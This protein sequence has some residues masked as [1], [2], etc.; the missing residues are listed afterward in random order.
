VGHITFVHGIANKPDPDTLLDTW[1][2]ALVDDDGVDLAELGVT[3]SMVYWAD[4]LY[5][6]AL[7]VPAA[8]EAN[9]LE[10]AAAA[11]AEDA[12]LTWL[13]DV[14]PAEQAFVTA[15]AGE[16]GLTTAALE[17]EVVSDDDAILVDSPLEA[18]PLPAWLKK[19][20]MRVL[21]R[22]VHHYLFDAECS[23]RPGETFQIRRDIRARA[24]AVLEADAQRPGPHVLIGHS[25][26][27]V[28]AYDV[29]TAVG[30]TP[31]VDA[32]VT[33]GSPLG[34]DEVKEQL[35]PPWTRDDGWP[36]QRLA[37]GPW[38]NVFD[39]LD[40]VCGGWHAA[41]AG[42]YRRKAQ[43]QVVDLR[44]HNTGSWRHSIG[45]YLGQDALREALRDVFA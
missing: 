26:G 9:K 5:A 36:G 35:T 39:G 2:A 13:S 21:L 25:L 15:L 38:T 6:A 41:I 19:R 32:F 7:P 11:T 37:S 45:K 24:L 16:V 10:L 3:T 17:P 43:E 12:D 42:D 34:I 4:M 30:G 22:D 23:P 28:I 20:L 29:L 27:S 8:Y 1:R 31:P 44:V 33:C 14:P 40:P 18:I